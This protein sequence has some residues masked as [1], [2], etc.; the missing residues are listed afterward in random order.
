MF[1][2]IGVSNNVRVFEAVPQPLDAS[3]SLGEE[4]PTLG[5]F[6]AFSKNNAF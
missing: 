2:T 6:T 3:G 4:L 5:L 1:L